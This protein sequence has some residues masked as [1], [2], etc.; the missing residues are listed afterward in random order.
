MSSLQGMFNALICMP[1]FLLIISKVHP[2]SLPII[3]TSCFYIAT[4][5]SQDP[6]AANIKP[7]DLLKVNQC[8]ATLDVLHY[9][10]NLIMEKVQFYSGGVAT[11]TP[12]SFLQLFLELFSVQSEL[13][14][15]NEEMNY[16]ISMLEV[17]LCHFE[18]TKY[19]VSIRCI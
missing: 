16:V 11:V 4:K 3:Q 9:M 5:N 7:E 19:R 13:R 8:D 14:I 17:L 15:N 6:K 10:S 2:K 12:L 18:L 1:Y